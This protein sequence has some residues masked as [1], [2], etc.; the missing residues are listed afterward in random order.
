MPASQ[1]ENSLPTLKK[2]LI[3]WRKRGCCASSIARNSKTP[4][5]KAGCTLYFYCCGNNLTLKMNWFNEMSSH[6]IMLLNK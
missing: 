5:L 6:V 1:A 4:E 3:I 2:L